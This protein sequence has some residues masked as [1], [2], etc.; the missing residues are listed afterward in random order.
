LLRRFNPGDIANI[1]PK[2]VIASGAAERHQI[3]PQEAGLLQLLQDGSLEASGK[4]YLARK[5]F[6]RYPAGLAG[7]HSV[8]FVFPEAIQLPAG[9]IRAYRSCLVTM[10]R[11]LSVKQYSL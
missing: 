10:G 1:D 3:L 5:P 4:G 7:A 11:S 6:T 9:A 2:Q 8:T